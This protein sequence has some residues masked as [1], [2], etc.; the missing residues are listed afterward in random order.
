LTRNLLLLAAGERRTR[1]SRAA[2][3]TSSDAGPFTTT[4]PEKRKS[5]GRVTPCSLMSRVLRSRLLLRASN[6]ASSL[7]LNPF[8]IKDAELSP[9]IM[10]FDIVSEN[11]NLQRSVVS[12][13]CFYALRIEIRLCSLGATPFI[14]SA[15]FRPSKHNYVPPAL[16]SKQL[17]ILPT[18]CICV[19]RMV[20]TIS[21]SRFSVVFLH[22]GAN[23]ELVPRIPRCTAC[24]TCSPPTSNVNISP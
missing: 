6:A 5:I 3:R 16:T 4:W 14:S 17:S 11:Q 13:H 1:S 22:P 18:S 24:F 21:R 23:A 7:V 8:S 9:Q 12:G 19:L 2:D 15:T 10:H 20:L